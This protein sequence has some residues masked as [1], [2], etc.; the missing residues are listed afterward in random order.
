[1]TWFSLLPRVLTRSQLLRATLWPGCPPLR[2]SALRSVLPRVLRRP[3]AAWSLEVGPVLR[4]TL[5]LSGS[6][7]AS[8]PWILGITLP[9]SSFSV[10]NENV[11]SFRKLYTT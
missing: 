4:W 7:L 10:S 1:M 9:V 5:G 2:P 11:L 3:L 8:R 6:E